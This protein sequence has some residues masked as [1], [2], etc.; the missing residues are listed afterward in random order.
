MVCERYEVLFGS[1]VLFSLPDVDVR[2]K[3]FDGGTALHIA[4]ANLCL[5]ASKCLVCIAELDLIILCR[6][7]PKSRGIYL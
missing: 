1:Y 6:G 3:E 7:F 4:A 5:E 2:C